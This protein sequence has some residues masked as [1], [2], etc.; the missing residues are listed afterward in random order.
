[1]K[2]HKVGSI[3]LRI[4]FSQPIYEQILDQIRNA[5][6][7]G[8]I[9]LGEKIPSVRQ[10]AHELKINPNTVMRAYRELE[11]AGLTEKR[12]GQGTFI[13]ASDEYVKKFKT[14]LLEQYIDEF[15]ENIEGL[16]FSWADVEE[17]V[18]KA[19]REGK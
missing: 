9:Q 13:T 15:L 17:Y 10:M 19:K 18:C 4:D 7:K 1:M 16:G 8:E 6:A 3:R 2:E 12:R 5:I 11:R 14:K